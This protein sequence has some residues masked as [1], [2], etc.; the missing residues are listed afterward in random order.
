MPGS[1]ALTS[2]N[3]FSARHPG[4]PFSA[5]HDAWRFEAEFDETGADFV[6]LFAKDAGKDQPA[7]IGEFA[8][9]AGS[10]REEEFAEEIGEDDIRPVEQGD[11]PGVGFCDFD[12]AASVVFRVLLGNAHADGVEIKGLDCRGPEFFGGNAEDPAPGPGIDRAPAFG[13]IPSRVAEKAE[14]GGG[15]RVFAGA[16]GHAGGNP[17]R[18]GFPL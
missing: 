16:E 13:K 3:F 7:A 11:F 18:I 5:G 10:G 2:L 1:R 4:A 15:R 14:A 6:R 9:E 8:R 17:N 12:P